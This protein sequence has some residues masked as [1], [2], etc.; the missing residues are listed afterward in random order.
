M[1]L[2]NTNSMV[3]LIDENSKV[4]QIKPMGGGGI[5]YKKRKFYILY[6]FILWYKYIS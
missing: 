1:L 5:D 2:E 4:I 3:P 6:M